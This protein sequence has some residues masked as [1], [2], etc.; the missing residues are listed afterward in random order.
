MWRQ[1]GCI[2]AEQ[3]SKLKNLISSF[4]GNFTT[5]MFGSTMSEPVSEE[6]TM[7]KEI[8]KV[9]ELV[10]DDQFDLTNI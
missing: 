6:K 7:K 3:R 5:N 9:V 10:K 2:T 8:L 4:E 1:N